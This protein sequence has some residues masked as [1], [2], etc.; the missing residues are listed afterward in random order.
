MRLTHIFRQAQ[1]SMI[2]VNAHKVNRG[3]FPVSYL[4]D[5]KKDFFFIKEEKPEMVIEH[6]KKIIFKHTLKSIEFS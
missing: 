5:V 3:E 2:I 4:P 1:D 6:L